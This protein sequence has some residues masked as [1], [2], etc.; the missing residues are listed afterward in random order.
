MNLEM[1]WKTGLKPLIKANIGYLVDI[2]CDR[3]T[4]FSLFVLKILKLCR[5]EIFNAMLYCLASAL[6][7]T[8]K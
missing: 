8:Q 2:G 1:F 3:K 5:P 4:S 7:E 6:K